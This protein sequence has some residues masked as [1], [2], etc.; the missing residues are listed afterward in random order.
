MVPRLWGQVFIREAKRTVYSADKGF[1]TKTEWMLDTEGVNLLD[2]ER[3]KGRTL[4]TPGA[5]DADAA[6]RRAN[7]GR[8]EIP[9]R[10]LLCQ[11]CQDE[12]GVHC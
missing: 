8:I 12:K 3:S 7:T 1:E 2:G 10:S 6:F 5:S 4:Q 9:L 11:F